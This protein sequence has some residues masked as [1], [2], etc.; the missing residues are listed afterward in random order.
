MCWNAKILT[1]LETYQFQLLF[2]Y[3]RLFL[4]AD[5]YVHFIDDNINRSVVFFYRESGDF[6][7]SSATSTMQNSV[8]NYVT[9]ELP[10]IDALTSDLNLNSRFV[11]SWLFRSDF[12]TSIEQQTS[13]IVQR[14]PWIIVMC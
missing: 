1:F 12:C 11:S 6:Y 10:Q 9:R 13:V 7:L 4:L 3:L 2:V 14:D 5:V 8:Q